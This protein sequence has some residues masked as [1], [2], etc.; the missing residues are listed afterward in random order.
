M[1]VSLSHEDLTV[2]NTKY[3]IEV[4]S[5]ECKLFYRIHEINVDKSQSDP[6]RRIKPSAFD[7][8]PKPNSV[9]MSVNWA[10]YMTAEETKN[11][12]RVPEKNGVLSF[13]TYQIK[14]SP[15]NLNVTHQPTHNRAH[16]IIHDVVS[17]KNDP[18]IRL[19]L[20]DACKW[21]IYI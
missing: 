7:P 18:E 15:I 11:T 12:A 1:A 13:I 16:S 3:E 9:Q 8:M 14:S 19:L 2:V 17:E 20:R 6:K 21:D 5:D 4:I 10:K